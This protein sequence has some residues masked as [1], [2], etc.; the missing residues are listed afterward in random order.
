ML[1]TKFPFVA[2]LLLLIACS[3]PATSGEPVALD[4]ISISQA[5]KEKGTLEPPI[6]AKKGNG[7]IYAVEGYAH[8]A[9]GTLCYNEDCSLHIYQANLPD[10]SPRTLTEVSESER[11]SFPGYVP[12]TLTLGKQIDEPKLNDVKVKQE[13]VLSTATQREIGALEKD[14]LALHLSDGSKVNNLSKIRAFFRV[15]DHNGVCELRY[16]G[17]VKAP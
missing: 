16:A 17:G 9:D 8:W 5:L 3:K 4:Q 2:S 15:V 6:C 11:D 12:L 7:T 1:L 10:G 13:G 14:S